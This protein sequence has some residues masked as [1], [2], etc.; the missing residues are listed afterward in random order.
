MTSLPFTTIRAKM[1]LV[2]ATLVLPSLVLLYLLYAVWTGAGGAAGANVLSRAQLMAALGCVALGVVL[3][4]IV[5]AMV[6]GDLSRQTAGILDTLGTIGIG[7][8]EARVPVTTRD[9]LGTIAQTLNTLLDNTLSLIQSQDERDR[10]EESIR[11]LQAEVSE[12]AE[13]NLTIEADIDHGLTGPIADAVNQMVAQLRE[14]VSNVQDATLQVSS[15]ANQIQ[16]TTEQLSRGS[17]AQATQ[18]VD[19]SAAVDEVAVSI[20][21]VAENT[22]QCLQVAQQA[23]DRAKVGAES[24]RGTIAGMDR[25]RDQVQETAKRIKRLGEGSQ[26]I[27]E[28]VQ[29]IGDIADR[30]SILALN[31]S[32]QAAMAGEAGLGFAV[33]AEE[34]ERLAE[35]S[36]DATKQIAT[37]IKSIQTETAEAVAAMEESTKEVVQGS[38]VALQAGE[39]LSQIDAESVRLTEIIQAITFSAKQQARGSE[40]IA[41]SMS[42]ISDVTQQTAEGTR[43]AAES[44]SELARLADEL[45]TSVSTF[46]LPG[47]DFHAQPVRRGVGNGAARRPV[48][49]TR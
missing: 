10:I 2:G 15:S 48:T 36:N 47:A 19:T 41:R 1:M 27:G 17:E 14:I 33:V 6:A 22:S 25:I 49:A 45:R 28:I 21:Q 9:E 35:R 23:R 7:D 38:R 18:I 40:A 16:A 46:R 37:L 42:E 26:S 32:I 34:V 11:R 24:V 3:S 29:L 43:Q 4:L 5:V 8:F 30:T 39:A 13:G 44:V 31:A 20:Q 12:V